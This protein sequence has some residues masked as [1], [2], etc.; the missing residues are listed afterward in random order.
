MP[1]QFPQFRC[2]QGAPNLYAI[3]G[4][5]HVTEWQPMGEDKWVV[6]Q[7]YASDYPRYQW[8]TELL[9][10]AVTAQPLSEQEW[11]DR[12]GE[13]VVISG[14]MA[15]GRVP[16]PATCSDWEEGAPLAPLTTFGAQA[17]AR[18]LLAVKTDADVRWALCSLAS[19]PLLVLGGGSNVLMHQDWD[20]R[21]LHMQVEGVQKVA[22]DGDAV[23]V[24][25]GAGESWHTWVMHAL[26]QGWNGLE[27]LA[28][29]PGSVGASP[30]QNI[31]AYGVEVKDRFAWLEAIHR[32]TG[33]LERFDG[34]RC[35]FGYR[36]SIFKQTDRDQWVIVRVAFH[37]ARRAPLNT[38]YGAIRAELEARGWERDTTHRQVA[39][40]VMHIRRSKLPDPAVLGNAGSFF[41]NPVVSAEVFGSVQ[42]SHPEVVH[43]PAPEGQVK[44]AAGW[45]I[46]RAG[47]KGHRRGACGVHDRQALVLVNYGGATGAEVWALAQAIMDDVEMKFGVRLEPEVNQIGL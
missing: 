36:D 18:H 41:K 25:V 26:D 31:G 12:L 19:E 17:Q 23:E 24:V 47:W 35:A 9:E 39:E 34:E 43:Y 4:P 45:L 22:D 6:H 40:A 3:E 14:E 7:H 1:A 30:M 32:E 42:A 5:R 8:V 38:Q 13:R 11:S 28:L 44:L 15:P 10:A 27:N 37:L 29:I 21:L 33:A 2:L 20:G 46:E 16:W